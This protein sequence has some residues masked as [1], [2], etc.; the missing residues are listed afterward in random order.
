MNNNNNLI[1]IS[2]ISKSPIQHRK[3]NKYTSLGGTSDS[4]E[5]QKSILLHDSDLDSPENTEQVSS[6]DKS[7][8]ANANTTNINSNP[9]T[10]STLVAEILFD[11]KTGSMISTDNENV[12]FNIGKYFCGFSD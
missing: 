6:I 11:P 4:S 12:S 1:N 9:E 3:R 8:E 2:Q 7:A 5:S 10:E